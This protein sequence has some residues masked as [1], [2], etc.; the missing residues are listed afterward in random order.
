MG[1]LKASELLAMLKDLSPNEYFCKYVSGSG[2]CCCHSGLGFEAPA[3]LKGA[4]GLASFR[5]LVD[6]LQKFINRDI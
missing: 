3:D 5:G 2:G 1:D 6:T 4:V